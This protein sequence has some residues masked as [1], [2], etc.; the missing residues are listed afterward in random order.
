MSTAFLFS[1]DPWKIEARKIDASNDYR[2]RVVNL[3]AKVASPDLNRNCLPSGFVFRCNNES[4][5]MAEKL[6]RRR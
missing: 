5:V 4:P 2:V 6:N 1:Q 3:L